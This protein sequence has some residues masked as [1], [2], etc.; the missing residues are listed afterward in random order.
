MCAYLRLTWGNWEINEINLITWVPEYF[1]YENRFRTIFFSLQVAIQVYIL[2][3]LWNEIDVIL[4]DD[5]KSIQFIPLHWM[6]CNISI[7]YMHSCNS[8]LNRIASESQAHQICGNI[9]IRKKTDAYD[10]N[11]ENQLFL[12]NKCW[13]LFS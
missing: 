4:W 9:C 1:L 5:S 8:T 7:I 12:D 3:E 10:V 2:F 13:I 6:H 11:A